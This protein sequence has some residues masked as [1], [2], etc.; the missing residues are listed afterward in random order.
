V[1]RA[2]AGALALAV[3]VPLAALAFLLVVT[4]QSAS[5]M[6]TAATT[7]PGSL[8]ADQAAFA[9][10]L[11][12]RSS[13][14]PV[15]VKAWVLAEG[16]CMTPDQPRGNCLFQKAPDGSWAQFPDPVAGADAAWANL[17]GNPG[18]YQAILDAIAAGD[19]LGEVTAI[20]NSPWDEG[21][22]GGDGS[23][24]LGLYLGLAASET[25]TATAGQ[26]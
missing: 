2:L 20:A 17:A 23:R 5:S 6:A 16:G 3:V 13:L 11:T 26:P 24:L 18:S 19:P 7:H 1:K 14:D 9:A 4:G 8:S 21:H 15:V 10:E 22:Y 25:A 12:S